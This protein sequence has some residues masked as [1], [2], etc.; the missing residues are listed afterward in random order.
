MKTY[1]EMCKALQ[2]IHFFIGGLSDEGIVYYYNELIT[3][4][5]WITEENEK[6]RGESP[7][8]AHKQNYKCEFQ[9]TDWKSS[10]N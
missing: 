3:N 9:R 1:E 2:D 6:G 7:H 4:Q 5:Q 8:K 10:K